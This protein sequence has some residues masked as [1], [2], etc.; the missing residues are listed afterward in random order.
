MAPAS[1]KHGK[2]GRTDPRSHRPQL[3]VD[4]LKGEA[5]PL[6]GSIFKQKW[7]K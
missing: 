1:P 3:G 2:A 7:G 5:Q 6:P 4:A